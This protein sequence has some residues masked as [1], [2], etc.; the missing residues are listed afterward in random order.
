EREAAG[1][2]GAVAR[3]D[4]D[5]RRVVDDI[6]GGRA[7]RVTAVAVVVLTGRRAHAIE[8]VGDDRPAPDADQ[9]GVAGRLAGRA[10]A[11]VVAGAERVARGVAVAAG[12]RERRVI[13]VH[14]GIEH[15][16][17]HAFALVGQARVRVAVPNLVRADELRTAV[18]QHRPHTGALHVVDLRQLG[19]R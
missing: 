7:R 3:R 8:G 9:L 18:G 16:D 6:A 12:R 19:E 13:G 1:H 10:I 5:I 15:A 4:A 11:E 2:A 17:D 14:A